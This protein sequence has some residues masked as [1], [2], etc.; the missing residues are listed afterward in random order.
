MMK[1]AEPSAISLS[2]KLDKTQ[3]CGLQAMEVHWGNERFRENGTRYNKSICTAS[4]S[5]HP[6]ASVFLGVQWNVKQED[7]WRWFGEWIL[8]GN[9][10]GILCLEHALQTG[11]RVWW[12]L[13]EKPWDPRVCCSSGPRPC[14]LKSFPLWS[15]TGHDG[16]VHVALPSALLLSILPSI[17]PFFSGSVFLFCI[18]ISI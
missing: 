9:G 1:V 2:F 3:S 16:K 6:V 12:A 13:Y 11:Q 18:C 14:C 5:I 15:C 4:D 7:L 10:G 17:I 8:I